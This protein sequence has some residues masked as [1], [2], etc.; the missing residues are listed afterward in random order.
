MKISIGCIYLHVGA[1]LPHVKK[2]RQ[3]FKTLAAP[4]WQVFDIDAFR[5][6]WKT[7]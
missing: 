7:I 2:L 1:Q 5:V 4:I 6:Y 3:R